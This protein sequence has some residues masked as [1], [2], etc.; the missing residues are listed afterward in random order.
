[1]I[2]KKMKMKIKIKNNY[3][4]IINNK[5]INKK[6]KFLYNKKNKKKN[7]NYFRNGI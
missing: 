2:F 5:F 7:N 6:I 4:H 1:M 3:I